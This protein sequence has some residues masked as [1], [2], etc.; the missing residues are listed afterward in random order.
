M[1]IQKSATVWKR[2]KKELTPNYNSQNNLRKSMIGAEMDF[3]EVRPALHNIF[4]PVTVQLFAY[5]LHKGP[6][7]E[8]ERRVGVGG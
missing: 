3:L 8:S 5:P 1:K 7:S 6:K 2:I 4:L